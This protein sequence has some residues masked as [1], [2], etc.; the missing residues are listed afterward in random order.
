M[1]KIDYLF[2]TYH[3]H[4]E[5][6]KNIQQCKKSDLNVKIAILDD[7]KDLKSWADPEGGQGVRTPLKNHK[8]YGF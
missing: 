8:I 1:F 7:F 4:H 2:L 3:H 5:V 6:S